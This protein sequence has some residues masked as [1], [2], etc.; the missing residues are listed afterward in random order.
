MSEL[1]KEILK[2]LKKGEKSLSDLSSE[3]GLS[4]KE[5]REA[6]KVLSDL[7][8]KGIVEKVPSYERR[9]HVF[10]LSK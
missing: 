1:E 6:R 2:A 3:L 4:G 7:V 8:R 5:L 9:V 10:K